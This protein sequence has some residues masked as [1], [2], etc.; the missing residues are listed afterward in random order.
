MTVVDRV[1]NLKG[2][3][4]L[5]GRQRDG[6]I[7]ISYDLSVSAPTSSLVHYAGQVSQ[8]TEWRSAA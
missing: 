7:S 6:K 3:F 2:I 5:T 8:T 1:V 4:L